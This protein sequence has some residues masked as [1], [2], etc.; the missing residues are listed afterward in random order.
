[1]LLSKT[2]MTKTNKIPTMDHP[3][4]GWRSDPLSQRESCPIKTVS[5][6]L[7]SPGGEGTQRLYGRMASR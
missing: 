5:T 3:T 2:M 7:Q 6:L 4:Q 1:M